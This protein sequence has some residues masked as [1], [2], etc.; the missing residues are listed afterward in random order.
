MESS[1]YHISDESPLPF[2]TVVATLDL[3][4]YLTASKHMA[5]VRL[6]G[7]KVAEFLDR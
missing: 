7:P 1:E 3:A 6:D 2:C 5:A 4:S